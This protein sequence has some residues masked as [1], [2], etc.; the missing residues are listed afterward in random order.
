MKIAI[1]S[2]YGGFS[3][4]QKGL[5]RFYQ[6]KGRECFFFD[7]HLNPLNL[8]DNPELQFI[9]Y[10]I[11]NPTEETSNEHGLDS[12]PENRTDPHLIQTIEELGILA[13]GAYANISIIEI[14]DDVKW[15]LNEDDGMET[16]HE[17]HRSWP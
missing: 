17:E 9:A 11:P 16:V 6:L 1:N 7:Y 12:R 15:V 2:C 5:K 13:N 10:D 14:P 8:E 4:S 3:L